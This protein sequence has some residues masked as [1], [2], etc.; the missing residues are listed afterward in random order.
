M[1]NQIARVLA[2]LDADGGEIAA[3]EEIGKRRNRAFERRVV[4]KAQ[5]GGR[6]VERGRWRA[7]D[8]N[9]ILPVAVSDIHTI[10]HRLLP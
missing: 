7:G 1:R 2:G 10:N 4:A 3:R 8:R 9:L 5:L 6:I